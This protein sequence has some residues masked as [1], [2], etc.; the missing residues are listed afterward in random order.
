ME[1]KTEGMVLKRFKQG[2]SDDVTIIYT[3]ELGKVM[4]NS[5]S[6]RKMESRLR[7]ALELFSLNKYH[8]VK[9]KKDS[10]YFRLIQAE[11]VKMFESI[12]MSLRKIGFAYLVVE[13]LHKFTEL[14]D[15]HSD[16]F[17][18]AKGIMELVE[19]GKYS[20]V[21]NIES[22]F[23]LRVLKMAGF[24]INVDDNYLK[25]NHVTKEMKNL[26]AAI[27]AAAEPEK[28]DVEY[29]VIREIN[30][31]IDAYMIYILGEDI[32]SARF[33]KGLK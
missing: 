16:M 19:S 10:K 6:T 12:R 11:P 20:N 3:R 31:L 22:Y 25:E 29:D 8:L 27:S 17:D 9:S 7:T 1:L 23:K 4:V 33:L 30:M 28:L 13:L 26:L 15:P 21:E 24:D 18:I 32:F 14:E 5:K 2:E